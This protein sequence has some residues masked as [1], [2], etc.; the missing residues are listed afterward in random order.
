MIPGVNPRQM[1]QAMRKLGIQQQDID[2]TEVIIRTPDKE[3]VISNPQVAKV[4]MMGQE[5]YQ[6][7]GQA[8]ERSISK[9]PEINEDDIKAVIDQTGVSKEEAEQAIKKNNGDLAAAILEL[10]E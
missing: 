8:E 4:N 9:E 7:V 3:I 5:T 1:R 2:A 10:K 6:I